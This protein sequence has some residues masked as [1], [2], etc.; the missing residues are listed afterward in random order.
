MNS[1]ADK[2]EEYRT[3]T[4]KSLKVQLAKRFGAATLEKTSVEFEYLL[5]KFVD[6][7]HV[8][9]TSYIFGVDMPTTYTVSVLVPKTWW[10]HLKEDHFPE[11][12]KRKWPVQYKEVYRDV[13]F[14]H[15]ALLPGFDKVPPGY[16]IQMFTE[17]YFDDPTKEDNYDTP[18]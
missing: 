16:E 5:D 17:P 10:E 11:W 7:V 3:Y 6:D 9:V 15:W 8:R 12:W 13:T 2:I 14:N 4:L 18:K 1:K